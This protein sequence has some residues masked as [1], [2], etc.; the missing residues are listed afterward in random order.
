MRIELRRAP[1][2][3]GHPL[4]RI[5]TPPIRHGAAPH[6]LSFLSH[7]RPAH[8]ASCWHAAEGPHPMGL[9][10]RADPASP[11]DP[12]HFEEHQP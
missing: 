12:V 10:R 8:R 2:H 9:R 6:P 7:G 4:R 3:G 5:S 1:P 11:A